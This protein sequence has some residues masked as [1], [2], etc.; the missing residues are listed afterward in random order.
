MLFGTDWPAIDPER[1]VA[2]IAALNLRP[3]AAS[4]VMG[5]NARRVFGLDDEA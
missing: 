2:E 4:L 5:E 1:A 3:D